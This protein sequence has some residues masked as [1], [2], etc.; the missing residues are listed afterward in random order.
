VILPLY[1]PVRLAEEMAVLDIISRG[2]VSYVFGLGYRAS[3]FEQFGLDLRARARLADEKLGLLRRLLTAGTVVH[4][5]RR[6]RITPRPH[7]PGGPMLMWGGGSLAAARRA[8]RCG[9]PLLART[10]VPGMQATYEA[11]CREHG[12]EPGPTLLPPRDTPS[13]CFVADDVD[14]AWAELG[15]Y[16]LH[17]A[18]MYAEWDPAHISHV[19]TVDELRANSLPYKIFSVDE[20]ASIFAVAI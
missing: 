18:H 13:A 15:Q 14:E 20:A 9:L 3:E 8:G 16:L 19:N 4:D 6:I 7:T 12:H 2:R 17:D 5:G 11:A 1:D 10:N